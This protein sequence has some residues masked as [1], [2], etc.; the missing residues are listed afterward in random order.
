M[1]TSI[2]YA[3]LLSTYLICQTYQRIFLKSTKSTTKIAI[4]ILKFKDFLMKYSV[5]VRLKQILNNYAFN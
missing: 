5:D 4:K 3:D 2:A 1:G